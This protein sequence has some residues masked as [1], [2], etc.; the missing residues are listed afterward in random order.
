LVGDLWELHQAGAAGRIHIHIGDVHKSLWF[1]AGNPVFA[2]SNQ[3]EDRLIERLRLH[4]LLSRTEYQNIQAT[5]DQTKGQRRMGELL[6]ESRLIRR[7]TLQ[8][9]LTDHLMH[10]VESV[11]A[12]PRGTWKFDPDDLCDEAFVLREPL[13]RV[14]MAAARDRIPLALMRAELGRHRCWQLQAQ[15]SDNHLAHTFGLHPNELSLVPR[16]ASGQSLATMLTDFSV[17][18][19]ELVGLAYVL[20]AAGYLAPLPEPPNAAPG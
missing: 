12:Y 10:V 6:L 17:D 1:R 7:L 20:R 14:L 5:Y 4:G 3:V 8:Q 19:R 9:A 18:E 16:L 2:S 15:A 11:L 13:G